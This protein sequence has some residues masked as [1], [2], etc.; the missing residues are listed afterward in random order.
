[1]ATIDELRATVGQLPDSPARSLTMDRLNRALRDSFSATASIDDLKESIQLQTSIPVPTLPPYYLDPDI[2]LLEALWVSWQPWLASQGYMLRPR[3]HPGW[4][5]GEH[6]LEK[7]KDLRE[8]S[9]CI[10]GSTSHQFHQFVLILISVQRH[11][12]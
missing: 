4:H 2:V 1:M 12:S 3:Y 8:D 6:K 9:T 11:G 5:L 7:L 10:G